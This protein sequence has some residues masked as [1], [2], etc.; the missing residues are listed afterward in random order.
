MDKGIYEA[1]M[2]FGSQIQLAQANDIPVILDKMNQSLLEHIIINN[3][4]KKSSL[5]IPHTT[6]L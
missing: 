1:G 5:I 3:G 4:I 6:S 2:F